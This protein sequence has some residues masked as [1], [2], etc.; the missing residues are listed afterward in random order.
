MLEMYRRH[1]YHFMHTISDDDGSIY[2]SLCIVY[3]CRY[4]D[5]GFVSMVYLLCLKPNTHNRCD[6]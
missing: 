2:I 5:D 6:I 4:N 1:V 3:S